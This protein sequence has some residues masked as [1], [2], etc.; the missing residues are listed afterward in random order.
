MKDSASWLFV[1]VGFLL[2]EGNFE[3]YLSCLM[4]L[5]LLEEVFIK[6]TVV[7]ATFLEEDN[8]LLW[9]F[10]LCYVQIVVIFRHGQRRHGLCFSRRRFH[11]F[12]RIRRT[13][14]TWYLYSFRTLF[15]LYEAV[16]DNKMKSSSPRPVASRSIL[17]LI[18]TTSS[19]NY[20]STILNS[21]VSW[22]AALKG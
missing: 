11:V 12:K 6:V 5:Y 1:R 21:S 20:Y 13:L 3:S 7:L 10:Q 14:Y 9:V 16:L 4:Q 19:T 22:G 8:V 2:V 17:L 18:K 15:V